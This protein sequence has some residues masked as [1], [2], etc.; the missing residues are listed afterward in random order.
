MLFCCCTQH[1]SGKESPETN[2]PDENTTDTT[3]VFTEKKY[4][5]KSGVITYE[6]V[7]NTISVHLKY[8]TVVY[9][10]AYGMKERRDTYSGDTLSDSFFSDGENKYRINY[11]SNKAYWSGKAYR[12][13]EPKFGWEEVTEDDKKSG[14]VRLIPDEVI[15][16]KK[17]TAYMVKSGVI[18]ARYAGWNDILM[19]SEIKSPGGSSTMKAVAVKEDDV[20]KGIFSVPAGYTIIH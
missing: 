20:P 7:L 5:I 4:L 10:D 12:G 13:T 18:T 9:F 14:K 1:Q 8:K 2:I 15:A 3:T 6:T 17:C 16:G 11:G 19:L